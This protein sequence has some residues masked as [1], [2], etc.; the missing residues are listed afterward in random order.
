MN[1]H[2]SLIIYLSSPFI[3]LTLWLLF[4][5]RTVIMNVIEGSRQTLTDLFFIIPSVSC[6]YRLNVNHL[7]LARNPTCRT[8]STTLV[9]SVCCGIEL[10]VDSFWERISRRDVTGVCKH[11]IPFFYSSFD[12]LLVLRGI[13]NGC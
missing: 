1:C 13:T 4:L 7:F 2:Y 10:V 5:M 8:P 9:A 6:F 11:G 12:D 3:L